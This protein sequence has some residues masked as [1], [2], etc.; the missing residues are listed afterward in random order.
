MRRS[1]SRGRLFV[2]VIY[3]MYIADV[4]AGMQVGIEWY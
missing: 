4:P 3:C 2:I 1:R